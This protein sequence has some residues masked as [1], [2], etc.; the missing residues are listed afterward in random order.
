[1]TKDELSC[2]VVGCSQASVDTIRA[3]LLSSRESDSADVERTLEPGSAT[4]LPVCDE[5]LRAHEAGQALQ[6][7]RSRFFNA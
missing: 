1:M 2:A 7:D 4:L 6:F 3:D 5:H